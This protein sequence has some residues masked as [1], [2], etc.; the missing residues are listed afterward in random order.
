VSYRIVDQPISYLVYIVL[1]TMIAVIVLLFGTG[2]SNGFMNLYMGVVVSS[3]ANQINLASSF[4]D[5]STVCV[6]IKPLP[7][8]KFNE[9]GFIEGYGQR[10]VYVK[11]KF[12][13]ME[14]TYEM[15]IVP[16]IA[17]DVTK[18]GNIFYTPFLDDSLAC[19]GRWCSLDSRLTQ[20]H[21]S[22]AQYIYTVVDISRLYPDMDIT[23]QYTR[24][25]KII[26]PVD[27]GYVCF[28]K[29]NGVLVI[30]PTFDTD[31]RNKISS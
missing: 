26:V 18:D 6:P 1:V 23:P 29:N 3:I 24:I 2:I 19:Y 31:P 7:L 4:P 17:T 22:D 30:N 14:S 8:V 20:Q 25:Y 9:F 11:I 10:F 27:K 13:N 12:F 16:I 15:P 21:L 28:Y 5:G